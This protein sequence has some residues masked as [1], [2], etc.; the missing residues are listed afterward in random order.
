MNINLKALKPNK[1][2]YNWNKQ[3]IAIF[4]NVKSGKST[5]MFDLL[6]QEALFIATEDGHDAIPGIISQ[7]VYSVSDI[8]EVIWQIQDMV[9]AGECPFKSIVFDTVDNLETMV[10]KYVI[11][12]AGVQNMG[13]VGHGK[14]YTEFD[15]VLNGIINDIKACQLGVHFIGHVKQKKVED[16]INGVEYEKFMP[17]VSERM[18]K[19]ILSDAYFMPFIF[20][21][22]DE[23]KQEHRMMAFRDT[24]QWLSGS[25]YKY[26]P[27]FTPLNV[28]AFK[29]AVEMAIKKEEEVKAGSTTTETKV[30]NKTSLN[31]KEIMA[32]GSMLGSK[33]QGAGH[34]D[35]LMGA[36]EEILGLDEN[37]KPRLFNQLKESQVETANV[38]VM[39]LERLVKELGLE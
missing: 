11:S 17:S 35:K 14:L 2:S 3:T 19:I 13:D 26:M 5:F 20:N 29:K 6:G 31:F 1:V 18:Q 25:R 28:E 21:K 15:K 38:L 12:A 34:V 9:E 22:L 37:G 23:N 39:K 36:V 32:K 4:G 7:R 30:E 10:Q 27:P 33:L 24:T 16:K 8:K